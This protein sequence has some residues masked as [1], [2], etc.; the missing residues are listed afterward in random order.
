[1]MNNLLTRMGKN[2]LMPLGLRAA[3]SS[4]DARC[5]KTALGTS[6]TGNF[7]SRT[8]IIIISSGEM[9]GVMK[10]VNYL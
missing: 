4:A 2:V 8:T 7:G 6:T 5:H 10:K 9:E 3:A 1:M